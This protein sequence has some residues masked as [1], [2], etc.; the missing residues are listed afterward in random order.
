MA[1]DA[2]QV[3]M[4]HPEELR[5]AFIDGQLQTPLCTT[6]YEAVRS[7]DDSMLLCMNT[8]PKVVISTAGML[9]GA[10]SFIISK[11]NCQIRRVLFCL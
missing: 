11:Q 2:T 4:N 3:Y 1:L 6:S 8:S 10:E 7:A 9:T 5:L